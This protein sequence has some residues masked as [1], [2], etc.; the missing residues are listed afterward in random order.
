MNSE[1]RNRNSHCA[2]LWVTDRKPFTMSEIIYWT[3]FWIPMATLPKSI[4][5]NLKHFK[6]MKGSGYLPCIAWPQY[7]LY[8]MWN[9]LKQDADSSFIFR[10]V[11]LIAVRLFVMANYRPRELA[12]KSCQFWKISRK[13]TFSWKLRG[14]HCKTLQVKSKH[15]YRYKTHTLTD[16][17]MWCK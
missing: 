15:C 16:A 13:R 2:E 12:K 4:S 14:V 5:M 1:H 9:Q 11:F 17:R 6:Y 8:S 3:M 7:P 10:N